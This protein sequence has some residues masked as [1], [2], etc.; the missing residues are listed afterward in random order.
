MLP[1]GSITV[2]NSFDVKSRQKTKQKANHVLH[3]L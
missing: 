2:K 1:V 3:T